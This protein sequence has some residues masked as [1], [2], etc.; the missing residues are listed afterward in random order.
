MDTI[1]GDLK[2]SCVLVYLDDINVFS[3]T[4]NE[5]VAHLEEV[6]K[7]LAKANLKLKTNKYVFSKEQIE[8][9]GYVVDKDGLH[10]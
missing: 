5:H 7:R 10:P 1:L 6:F 2:I 4:F 8:Y 9:L 3:R